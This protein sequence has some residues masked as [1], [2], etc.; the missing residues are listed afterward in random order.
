MVRGGVAGTILALGVVAASCV[1]AVAGTAVVVREVHRR[2]SGRI[3]DITE[4]LLILALGFFT[5][6]GG[7][8]LVVTYFVGLRGSRLVR[9]GLLYAVR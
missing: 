4:A 2:V 6:A 9:R 7:W 5:F 8:L 1:L 3:P